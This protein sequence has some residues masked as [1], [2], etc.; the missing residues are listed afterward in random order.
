MAF[1]FRAAQDPSI[2]DH[3]IDFRRRTAAAMGALLL[4][5]AP[6]ARHPDPVLAVDLAVQAAFA[7]MQNHVV[8]D[9]TRAAGRTLST[10]ELER[11]ITRLALAYVGLDAAPQDA[12]GEPIASARR[13]RGAASVSN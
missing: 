2:R 13:P 4:A 10:D 3:A 9:G 12:A 8:L 1:M 11:E 6:R 7:L 5:K